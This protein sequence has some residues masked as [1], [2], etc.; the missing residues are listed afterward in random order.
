MTDRPME[1]QSHFF[2]LFCWSGRVGVEF[3]EKDTVLKG[4]GDD[5]VESVADTDLGIVQLSSS[6]H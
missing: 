4:D 3:N 6:G 5:K 1:V 2:P